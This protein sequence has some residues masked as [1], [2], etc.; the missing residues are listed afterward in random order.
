MYVRRTVPAVVQVLCEQVIPTRHGPVSSRLYRDPQ[1]AVGMALWV[2][3]LGG[4]EPVLARV[5]SS[6]FTSEGLRGLDCDCVAQLE[7]ALAIIGAEGRGVVFYLLQE[8]RG[9]GLPNKARDRSIVQQSGGSIDT[10]AAYAQL[11]LR[12]DPRTYDVI[13]PMCADLGVVAPLTLMTNNPEK[14]SALTNAGLVV[15]PIQHELAPSRYNAQYLT[16]KAKFGHRLSSHEIDSATLPPLQ[17]AGCA[18]PPRLGRF[19]LAA[20][21]LLP[22]DV[23]GAPA[24]FFAT[25]YVDE[26][27]GHD[28]MLLSHART[29]AIEVRHV[30]REELESRI[31]GEGV[32]TSRYRSAL[33]NIVQR[34]AGAVLAVPADA[35]LLFGTPG[36]SHED[37]LALLRAHGVARGAEKYEEVA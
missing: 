19:V 21:Y 8:G 11:G 36:P 28:R 20:S 34:G 23:E 37:D 3:D 27:S 14:I 31:S 18:S 25:S 2:G 4:A 32:Q 5:H 35:R 9:A 10:Y 1:G 16:A 13:A 6:C 22:V 33:S 12:P 17:L 30:F 15:L 24:W 29:R 26:A 7:V